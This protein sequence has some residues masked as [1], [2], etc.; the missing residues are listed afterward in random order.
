ML[1]QTRVR[2][3]VIP[4]AGTILSEVAGHSACQDPPALSLQVMQQAACSQRPAARG[5]RKP[6]RRPLGRSP[7]SGLA[8]SRA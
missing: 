6:A 2:L 8:G 3:H 7:G 1:R 4:H 5:L